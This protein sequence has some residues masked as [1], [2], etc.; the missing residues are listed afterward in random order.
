MQLEIDTAAK[1]L[2]RLPEA[3]PIYQ[4]DNDGTTYRYTKAYNYKLIFT[5]IEETKVVFIITVRHDAEDPDL[6][7]NDLE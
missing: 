3:N 2:E 4:R 6:V 7:S 1:R 5:V